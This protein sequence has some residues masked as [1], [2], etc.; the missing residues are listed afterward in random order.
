MYFSIATIL[1]AS[2]LL[3]PPT[4][5][6]PLPNDGNRQNG[7]TSCSS[8][9]IN[10]GVGVG[11]GN[12]IYRPNSN[13]VKVK[14]GD[15]RSCPSG[16]TRS[17]LEVD[18]CIEVGGNDHRNEKVRLILL[19]S[20]SDLSKGELILLTPLS[21]KQ[22]YRPDSIHR[23]AHSSQPYWAPATTSTVDRHR[24]SHTSAP[25]QKDEVR[26]VSFD[27]AIPRVHRC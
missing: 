3:F 27:K 1:A 21:Q 20:R 16:W 4:L 12:G 24:A 7:S 9:A 17:L 19:Q 11:V 2:T 13:G 14:Q 25:Q 23:A 15:Q 10:V 26:H 18:L 8:D 5:A 22:Q 6:A